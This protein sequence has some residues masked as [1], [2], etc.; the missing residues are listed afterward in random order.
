MNT[1]D[2]IVVAAHSLEQGVAWLQ[3]RLGVSLPVGG[4]HKTM[5]THN[6]L[7]R[8]GEQS[9]FELIAI[10]PQGEIPQSPRWFDLDQA[11][12]RESLQ[13]EPRLITWVM[14]TNNLQQLASTVDFDIGKPTALSRDGLSWEIALT[15]D[16]RLLADGLLPYCLQWHSS[17]HPATGMAE[18]G[19]Q[20]AS[21]TLFHNRVD[22]L[23]ER[24]QALG[25][26]HLVQVESIEDARAPYLSAVID[27]PKGQVTLDSKIG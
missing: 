7:M 3:E 21:L 2:H 10:N 5:G 20:L 16:G 13:H 1:L 9:Y 15:D 8:L 14:N 18:L 12:L 6:H 23:E 24:L 25:A 19:C 26:R 17:P 4:V 22:W 27:C 11:L